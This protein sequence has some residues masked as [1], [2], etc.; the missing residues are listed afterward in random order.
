MLQ[1]KNGRFRKRNKKLFTRSVFRLMMNIGRIYFRYG[2]R[3]MR[4]AKNGLIIGIVSVATESN[5][6]K[7]SLPLIRAFLKP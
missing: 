3:S 7:R 1:I 5:I 2:L 6:P 4:V